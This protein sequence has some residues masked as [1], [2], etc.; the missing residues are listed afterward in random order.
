M[1]DPVVAD[2]G[3]DIGACGGHEGEPAAAAADI[4]HTLILIEPLIQV[5][6]F[7]ELLRHVRIELD[8]RPEPPKEIGGDSQI[9]GLCPSVALAA[10]PGIYSEDFLNDDDLRP[11]HAV[12]LRKIRGKSLRCSGVSMLIEVPR[13]RLAELADLLAT[14]PVQRPE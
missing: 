10:N 12:R 7:L 13:I 11:G 6:S 8:A 5:Q 1:R 3:I 9:P 14:R 4:G 2:R